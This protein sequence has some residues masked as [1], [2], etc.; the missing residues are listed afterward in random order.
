METTTHGRR[1]LRAQARV[2]ASIVSLALLLAALFVGAVQGGVAMVT[3][4]LH[5]LGMTTDWLRRS[6]VDDYFW[7][8]VFLLG[9]AV[10]SLLAVLGLLLAWP[11][12]WASRIEGLIGFRWPWLAAVATGAVLFVFEIIELFVVPFHP[13]MHPLL[14]AGSAAIVGLA[15]SP[16]A[17]EHLAAG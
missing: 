10:A 9:I 17:R 12:R 5:P 1:S 7:P 13:V 4:P 8:G 16:G 14:L 11:W 15:L 6:P 2:P 3:D